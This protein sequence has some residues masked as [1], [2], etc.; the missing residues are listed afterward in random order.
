M[1]SQTIGEFTHRCSNSFCTQPAVG[2][3]DESRTTITKNRYG[4]KLTNTIDFGVKYEEPKLC[5]WCMKKKAGL[6]RLKYPLHKHTW[7]NKQ[8]LS[9]MK[10]YLV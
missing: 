9:L 1:H 8:I 6:D 3:T 4:D 10:R 7:E 2:Q 5:Y